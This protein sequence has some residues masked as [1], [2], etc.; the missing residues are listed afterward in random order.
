MKINETSLRCFNNFNWIYI[1]KKAK[2]WNS[3]LTLIPYTKINFYL[4][5]KNVYTV[6]FK[7]KSVYF[8]IE[9]V[10][11]Y[12]GESK[13]E[14]KSSSLKSQIQFKIKNLKLT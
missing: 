9:I 10:F 4:Y 6:L 2:E 11:L 14:K 7:S 13:N 5:D 3:N 12:I 1:K 8:L